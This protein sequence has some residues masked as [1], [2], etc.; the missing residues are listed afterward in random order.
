MQQQITAISIAILL[1]AWCVAP[2]EQNARDAGEW[3]DEKVAEAAKA[4]GKFF[5]G[6]YDSTADLAARNLDVGHLCQ[7][8]NAI[9]NAGS[10][11]QSRRNIGVPGQ[12][13]C[14]SQE[15]GRTGPDG[16]ARQPEA[17]REEGGRHEEQGKLIL[18]RL[19]SHVRSSPRPRPPSTMS[20]RR[21]GRA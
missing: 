16:R 14:G 21:S 13:V 5:E 11:Q 17:D 19:H 3:V 10:S 20:C 4:T 8:R 1:V 18:N 15:T 2:S 12:I 9:S 6:A 7:K